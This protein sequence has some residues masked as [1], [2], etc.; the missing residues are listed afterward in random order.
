MVLQRCAISFVS[1]TTGSREPTR[2][3]IPL[4][5]TPVS[6]ATKAAWP[7]PR[8]S[9]AARRRRAEVGRIRPAGQTAV[10]LG[11]DRQRIDD[12]HTIPADHRE[13]DRLACGIELHQKA[14]ASA[15]HWRPERGG[16]GEVLGSRFTTDH[17]VSGSVHSNRL[18]LLQV[19]AADAS[20]P[21]DASQRRDAPVQ[22]RPVHR[23]FSPWTSSVRRRSSTPPHRPTGRPSLSCFG[24]LLGTSGE[25]ALPVSTASNPS[26][27][28]IPLT[29]SA[30]VP[31]T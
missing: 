8:R 18:A 13:P 22:M 27:I 15:L 28:A 1:H 5:A 7:A 17:G 12:V 9:S 23:S 19:T 16:G 29:A 3:G 2:R 20:G 25:S 4:W 14:V 21:L 11:I 26:A 6:S 10:P 31:P 30:P 24:G